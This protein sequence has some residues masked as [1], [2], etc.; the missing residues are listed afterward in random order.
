MEKKL[1]TK[2]NTCAQTD[3]K[4]LEQFPKQ[5]FTPNAIR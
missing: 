5:L 4:K 1:H 3:R 2:K